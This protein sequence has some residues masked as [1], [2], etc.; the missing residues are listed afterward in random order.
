MYSS[1]HAILKKIACLAHSLAHSEDE[2]NAVYIGD[3]TN[4]KLHQ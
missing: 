3:N 2:I 1:S 4:H